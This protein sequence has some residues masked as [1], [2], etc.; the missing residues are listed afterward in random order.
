ML[1]YSL[2]HNL[3]SKALTYC[4]S[5]STEYH[6]APTAGMDQADSEI[7]PV[8]CGSKQFMKHVFLI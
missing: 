1:R 4:L 8:S 3:S 2:H 5:E 7:I 6:N